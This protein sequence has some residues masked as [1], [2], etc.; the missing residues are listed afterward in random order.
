MVI[1]VS[2]WVF[3]C[4]VWFNIMQYIVCQSNNLYKLKL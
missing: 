4:E 1:F 2:G 3:C